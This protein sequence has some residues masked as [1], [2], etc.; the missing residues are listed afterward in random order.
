MPIK[1][2]MAAQLPRK[3]SASQMKAVHTYAAN[4]MHKDGIQTKKGTLRC[5]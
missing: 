1:S 2:R 4:A 3:S 5:P